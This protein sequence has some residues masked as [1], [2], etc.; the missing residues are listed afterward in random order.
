MLNTVGTPCSQAPHPDRTIVFFKPRHPL[1]IWAFSHSGTLQSI[2]HK[3]VS[4]TFLKY[5]SDHLYS[6]L[7]KSFYGFEMLLE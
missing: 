5:N 7:F 4:M 1:P 3:G 2:F 6:L